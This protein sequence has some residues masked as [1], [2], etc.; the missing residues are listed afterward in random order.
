MGRIF[1][2][3]NY[4]PDL[5]DVLQQMKYKEPTLRIGRRSLLRKNN[6]KV[7]LVDELEAP[8]NA[9]NVMEEYMRSLW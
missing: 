2:K 8:V 1:D 9:P 6:Y 5:D 4:Q 7:Y 3:V